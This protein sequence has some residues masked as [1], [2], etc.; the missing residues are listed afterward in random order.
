MPDP[1]SEAPKP[2]QPTGFPTESAVP[3]VSMRGW[4]PDDAL[5]EHCKKLMG[6]P[7]PK[8]TTDGQNVN[9]TAR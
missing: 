2:P 9:R 1:K 8:P 6:L 7:D 3:V 4:K 5:L